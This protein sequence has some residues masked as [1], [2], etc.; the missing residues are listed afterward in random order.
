LEVMVQPLAIRFRFHFYGEKPTNRLDKPEYFLTHVLDLLER[1]GSFISDML[2]PIL[3]Q[4]VLDQEA[5]ESVYTDALSAFITALLPMVEAK[6]LSFLP[7]ISQ[8]PQLFS[9]F[10]HELLAFDTALRDMWGYIPYPR[11]V[12]DWKGLTWKVLTKHGY[13]DQWLRVEKEFALSRYRD[14]RDAPDSSKLD[15]DTDSGQTKPTKGAIRVNDLLETVTDRYRGLSSFSHKMK[16]LLE[17][18]LAIFDDYHNYLHGAIQAYLVSSHTAGRLLH[19]Q[20][21]ND[22]FGLKGLEALLKVYGSAEFL[23]RKMSDWSDDVFFVELWEEL[24]YRAQ[25]K[26]GRNASLGT[27]LKFEEVADKT[28]TAIRTDGAHENQDVEGSGLFDQTASAYRRLRERSE[29]E[30]LRFFEVN[31]KAALQTYSRY[32]GWSTL[33][34]VPSDASSMAPSPSLDGFFQTTET[35]V[36]YLARVL[37]AASLRR[38]I[39]QYCSVVQREIYD[40][41]LMSHTFSAAGAAQ[42]TKDVSEVAAAIE[43]QSKLRLAS[44]GAM[45]RLEEAVFL[46]SLDATK[47]STSSED[48]EWGFDE[49][50]D[51]SVAEAGKSNNSGDIK[52]LGLR[53]A[54][55]L[56]FESNESARLALKDLGLFH[57]SENE[58]R[59]IVKR[60]EELKRA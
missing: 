51:P 9:H 47:P 31:V 50:G 35:L 22:A 5:L 42:L 39:K 19:G 16:F 15:F 38:V 53:E 36:Q 10:L 52:E 3:D 25:A 6:C 58:A 20:S 7:Q 57:L 28:S 56:V 24:Q 12:T 13:F 30:M 14:I 54:E 45:K 8:Q 32:S 37:S 55:K 41:V 18:Q 1:H 27:D 4:R 23:E 29:E 33:T 44:T 2:G 40:N 43:G 11:M 34:D 48:D 17:I 26:H 46:L 21:E 49:D 60:R 59:L